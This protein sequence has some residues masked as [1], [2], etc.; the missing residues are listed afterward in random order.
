[1]KL[2]S[3]ARALGAKPPARDRELPSPREALLL[4]MLE[5]KKKPVTAYALH[6]ESGGKLPLGS[7]YVSLN[8]MEAKGFVKSQHKKSLGPCDIRGVSI[9]PEGRTALQARE[10]LKRAYL[11]T[12]MGA[13]AQMKREPPQTGPWVCRGDCRDE[14]RAKDAEP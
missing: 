11:R 14:K 3:L 7:L 2:S 4:G 13:P 10:E 6:K 1:M 12:S 8:R 9:T 5:G